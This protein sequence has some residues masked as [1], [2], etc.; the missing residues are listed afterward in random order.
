MEDADAGTTSRRRRG[1]KDKT[2]KSDKEAATPES[3]SN[4]GAFLFQ[5]GSR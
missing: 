3:D 4:E 2:S 1:H 5:M